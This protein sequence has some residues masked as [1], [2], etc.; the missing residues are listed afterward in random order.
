M[1]VEEQAAAGRW[2][3]TLQDLADVEFPGAWWRLDFQGLRVHGNSRLR[4]AMQLS[5]LQ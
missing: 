4:L 2:K 3:A 1:C 5:N